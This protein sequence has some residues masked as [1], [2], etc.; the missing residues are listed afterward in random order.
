MTLL[1]KGKSPGKTSGGSGDPAAVG[2]E[3]FGSG[4]GMK[5]TPRSCLFFNMI[6]VPRAKR[7]SISP[8]FGAGWTWFAASGFKLATRRHGGIF[9]AS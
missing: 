3:I 2:A 7:N 1:D 4:I 6:T 8:D 9:P 5:D